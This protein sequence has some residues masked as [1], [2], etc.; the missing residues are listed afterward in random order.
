MDVS[1]SD[2]E[3]QLLV[4]VSAWVVEQGFSEGQRD[5]ELVDAAG[6]PLAVLA[7]AWPTGLQSELS[8]PVALLLDEPADVFSAAVEHGYRPFTTVEELKSCAHQLGDEAVPAA[9]EL[10]GHGP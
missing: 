4:E 10:I 6:C 2:S 7:L 9:V 5:H 8:E 3:A 1:P